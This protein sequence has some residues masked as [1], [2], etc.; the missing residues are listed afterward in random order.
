MIESIQKYAKV[1][2]I[3]GMLYPG[4]VFRMEDTLR[5]LLL[6]EYWTSIE[7]PPM[8]DAASRVRARRML[9]TAGVVASYVAP[10][11]LLG[12]G[13]NLNSLDAEERAKAVALLKMGVDEAY[14]YG[15]IDM[16]I[17]AGKFE[18]EKKADYRK[19]LV[20]S[21]LEVCEYAKS[22]GDLKIA[23][24]IFDYDVDKC[25]IIGPADEAADFAKD[26]CKSVDNFGLLLDHSHLPLT[27][28][29]PEFAVNAVKDYLIH[30]HIGNNVKPELPKDTPVYGDQ[31]PRFGFPGGANGEAELVDYL[32]NLLAVGFLNE[33]DPPILSFEV[34]PTGAGTMLGF[35]DPGLVA[36]NVKR[37][38][39]RAWAMV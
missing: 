27:H 4:V 39:N 24:E 21:V 30:A 5:E 8:G 9:E 17:L 10:P 38:L 31:H 6:D 33:K 32:R 37:M 22:Q 12:A 11:L 23:L 1:G 20:D 25:V 19:A 29:T 36:A 3:Q 34:K 26:I 18:K 16:S 14:D 2:I 35:E 7:V 15:C 13:L 28:E